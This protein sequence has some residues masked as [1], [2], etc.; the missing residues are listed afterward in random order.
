MSGVVVGIP[1]LVLDLVQKGL[2]ERGFH[3]SLF[4]NLAYRSEATFEEWGANSGEEI[5][6]SRPGLLPPN[7]TPLTPGVDP[8]PQTPT[9]E[10]WTAQLKRYADTLDIHMPTSAVAAANLFMRQIQSLG[11]QAGQSVNRLPR[12]A[13]FKSYTSGWTVT[14]ASAGAGATTIHVASLNGFTDVLTIST[15]AKAIAVSPAN[16]L[17]IT[18]GT[19]GTKSVVGALPDD[20][21]DP[22][23]PGTLYLSAAI[24]G[25]GV[26]ARVY[27]KSSAAPRI[28]RAGGGNSVD[29][30][31]PGDTF[32]LQDAINATAYLR[33]ANVQPH[34]DGLYHCHISAL[35]NAQVFADPAFQRLNTALPEHS[36]YK[37]GFIGTLGGVMFILNTESPNDVNSGSKVATGTKAYYSRDIGTETVNEDGT[38]IGR[39]IITGRDSIYERG[40]DEASN[41]VSEAGLNGKQGE[42][43]IVNNNVQ[44]S[45]DRI[46]LIMRAPQNRLQDIV[47]VTWSITTSFPVPSDIGAGG[48][49]RFK[50]ALVI[51]HAIG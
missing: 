6:M 15:Q 50:R 8:T 33:D 37:E 9:F 23:G 19:L 32:S 51:E 46:R 36:I 3:D 39:M 21:T 4:P 25:S 49:E 34:S 14:T 45:T 22:Y 27:V 41:Y 5:V 31:G 47:S 1:P 44:V 20:P 24:G 28:I 35:A 48:P 10:Q 11:L 40:L 17:A 42:F 26:G 30:I 18:L 16:P 29:S 12:N 43:D 13:L 7:V 2:I 38:R